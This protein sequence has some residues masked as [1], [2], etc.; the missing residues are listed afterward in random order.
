MTQYCVTTTDDLPHGTLMRVE[1][2]GVTMCLARA[3]DGAIYAIDDACSHEQASL[4]EGELVDATWVE[5][6]MHSSLFDLKTGAVYGLPARL[7]V[8]SFPVSVEGRSV[9]VDV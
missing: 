7:P 4:S 5:C 3:G 8:R 9:F 6:P 2:G 1:A